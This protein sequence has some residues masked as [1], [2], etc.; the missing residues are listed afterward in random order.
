MNCRLRDVEQTHRN[1]GGIITGAVPFKAALVFFSFREV[2]RVKE[3]C[4]QVQ[5]N[6]PG[7]Q[8]QEFVESPVNLCVPSECNPPLQNQQEQRRDGEDNVD[9]IERV[10]FP[11]VKRAPGSREQV[12]HA[13][14]DDYR[15]QRGNEFETAHQ[16]LCV[17][18]GALSLMQLET[19]NRVANGRL[20]SPEIGEM[21]VLPGAN[22]T[23]RAVN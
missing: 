6:G 21:R 18:H 19:E 13:Q 7:G 8:D 2:G 10:F 23:D 15:H 4:E 5:R 3:N 20:R 22:A 11:S 16:V 17:L 12:G 14:A 1:E 9:L